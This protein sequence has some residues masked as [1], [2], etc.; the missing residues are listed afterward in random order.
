MSPTVW[1]GN[2]RKICCCFLLLSSPVSFFQMLI[3]FNF[4]FYFGGYSTTDEL[5]FHSVFVTVSLRAYWEIV[6]DACRCFISLHAWER[7]SN[8]EQ[9]SSCRSWTASR[10]TCC[11]CCDW[12]TELHASVCCVCF[13]WVPTHW[14]IGVN[15]LWQRAQKLFLFFV[16]LFL[17]CWSRI[18]V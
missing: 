11:C 12:L 15:C 14:N 6:S 1:C 16:C 3:A 2:R 17:S 10:W 7:D 9:D 8:M 13:C 18:S 5:W 4:V